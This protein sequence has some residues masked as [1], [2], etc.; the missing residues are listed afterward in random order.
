MKTDRL[1]DLL[2]KRLNEIVYFSPRNCFDIESQGT[3]N[4]LVKDKIVKATQWF[5]DVWFFIR[6]SLKAIDQSSDLAPFVSIVFFY[7]V[8][9]ELQT[10]F[11]AEWDSYDVIE[12][13]NHPQPHWHIAMCEPKEVNTFDDL[14]QDIEGIGDFAELYSETFAIPNIYKMHFAMAGD[15]IQNSNMI[16]E[17]KDEDSLVEWI[18]NLLIHIRK[19]LEYVKN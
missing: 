1:L 5:D 17:V 3:K 15:W 11:R 6:I 2:K 9:S 13:Y 7:E 12:G 18:Y 19:E 4:V 10:L 16:T 14:N 8:N